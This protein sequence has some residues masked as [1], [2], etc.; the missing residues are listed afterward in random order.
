LQY[1]NSTLLPGEKNTPLSTNTK[2]PNEGTYFHL[3]QIRILGVCCLQAKLELRTSRSVE[4]DVWSSSLP[5]A[6][7]WTKSEIKKH[8]ARRPHV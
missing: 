4:H 3:Q 7:Q 1:K 5:F 8:V 6:N 2:N